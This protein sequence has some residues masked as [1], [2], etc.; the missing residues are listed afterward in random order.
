MGILDQALYLADTPGALL[1]GLLAGKPGT[2]KTGREVLR[3]GENQ[4]GLD[5]GDVA[6][7]LAEMLLD[8]LNWLGGAGLATKTLRSLRGIPLKVPA[9]L[10][11]LTPILKKLPRHTLEDITNIAKKKGLVKVYHGAP[12]QNALGIMRKGISL[13]PS[14]E[15]AAM[16]VAKKYGIT[17]TE[18]R[19]RVEPFAVGAGYGTETARLSTSSAPIASRWASHFPQGEVITDL[20]EKAR[21]YLAAK[22]R[23]MSPSQL[24]DTVAGPRKNALRELGAPDL[25]PNP[26]YGHIV[27]FDVDARAFSNQTRREAMSTLNAINRGHLTAEDAVSHWNSAYRDMKI[28][29][30]H[31]RNPRLLREYP[32]THPGRLG[33]ALFGYNVAARQNDGE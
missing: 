23:G 15:H 27:E 14:G 10:D 16:L 22:K 11:D 13:P 2:R 19:H 6:G 26:K 18:W 3:L 7:F 30:K 28:A 29:P 20:N 9:A 21:M 32:R 12:K 25:M 4:P 33:A 8:P 24:W 1:R 5:A 31:A 17:P